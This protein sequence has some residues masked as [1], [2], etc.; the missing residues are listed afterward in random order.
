M[1]KN[2]VNRLRNDYRIFEEHPA[3]INLENYEQESA[4]LYSLCNLQDSCLGKEPV[5]FVHGYTNLGKHGGGEETWG[6]LPELIE[7]EGYAVFE[8]TWITS[9]RFVDAGQDLADAIDKINLITNKKVHI[10]AHSFGG[11]LSRTYL[12]NLVLLRPYRNNVQSL[13]TIGTPH[14]GIFDTDGKYYGIDFKKGQDPNVIQDLITFEGCQQT[15]CHQTGEPT[16]SVDS[17]CFICPKLHWYG[18]FRY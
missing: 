2:P 11:L 6:K 12:Q 1:P 18:Y 7:N 10:I 16:P 8:F 17:S 15:S 13:I 14:S 3:H 4:R 5:L 9:A